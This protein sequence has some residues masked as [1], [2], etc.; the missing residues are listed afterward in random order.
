LLPL[1]QLY[2]QLA[3]YNQPLGNRLLVAYN[4]PLGRS[5]RKTQMI[6]LASYSKTQRKTG[7]W[8]YESLREG[9][10]AIDGKRRRKIKNRQRL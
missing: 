10:I 4:Q 3:G 7:S 1:C 2:T 5:K 6:P 9:D 8:S